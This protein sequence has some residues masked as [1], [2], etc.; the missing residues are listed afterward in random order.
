MKKKFII[1]KIL[2]KLQKMLV[3]IFFMYLLFIPKINGVININKKSNNLNFYVLKK[4]KKEYFF[5]IEKNKEIFNDNYMK[6]VLDKGNLFIQD[7]NNFNKPLSK[8]EIM[9]DNIRKHLNNNNYLD[10]YKLS[11]FFSE[12]K[13]ESNQK[14]PFYYYLLTKKNFL[15]K[16]EFLENI[17]SIIID[18]FNNEINKK[19]QSS[20][21]KLFNKFKINGKTS[22]KIKLN[23]N[24]NLNNSEISFLLPLIERNNYIFFLQNSTHKTDNRNQNNFGLGLRKFSFE[25]DYLL[26]VNSFLDYD[27]SL[28]NTRLGL[29]F[30]FW[31]EF[32]KFNINIYYGLSRWWHHNMDN[33]NN[34]KFFNDINDDEF[35]SKPATGLDF[36]IKGYF[37]S[38][39][40]LVFKLDYSK[41]FGN[42]GF[43]INSNGKNYEKIFSDPFF[44]FSID[45]NPIPLLT[46]N[47]K[48][49]QTLGKGNFQFGISINLNLNSSF[50]NQIHTKINDV[51]SSSYDH[52]YDFVDR[53]NNMML[54]Y[55]KKYIIKIFAKKEIIGPPRG[56][57]FLEMNVTH[58]NQISNIFFYVDSIFLQR[59]GSVG[60][61][62]NDSHNKNDYMMHLP[63]YDFQN[64]NSN[65]YVLKIV[66]IDV[67]GNKD[68]FYMRIEVLPPSLNKKFSTLSIYPKRILIDSSEKAKIVFEARDSDNELLTNLQ[69]VS[70]IVERFTT[71]DKHNIHISTVKEYPKGTYSAFIT[72]SSYGSALFKVKIGDKIIKDINDTVEFIAPSVDNMVLKI[73]SKNLTAKVNESI[74]LLIIVYDK[75]GKKLK[76]SD[77]EIKNVMAVDQHG[78][79]RKDSGEIHIEDITHKKSYDGKYFFLITD[80]NGELRLKISDPH[81]IGVRTYFK[82]IANNY[83]SKKI[84][85]IFTVPTSPKTILAK[86]YGHMPDFI[87]FNGMKFKRPTLSIERLGD[88]VNHNLNEDWTKFTWFNADAFCKSQNAR[89]PTKDELIDFYN[90]HPGDDLISNYGWPIVEKS[91][92]MFWTST[93]KI[94]MYFPDP[95]HY[96]VDFITG[97]IDQGIVGN[98][99]PFICVDD[100]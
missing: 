77:V 9:Q 11:S 29:G 38:V 73:D 64:I 51:F 86:M 78:E 26:G 47:I 81:G 7:N 25:N 33:L 70:F 22:I 1:F 96:H 39:P 71:Y 43:K 37:P 84:D 94:N 62:N 75:H 55:R 36:K 21:Y 24:L 19:V 10:N 57:H 17:K 93:P 6:K 60:L 50:Y 66:A 41:Y 69:D 5:F 91:F 14:N 67:L 100:N 92:S 13:K 2:N 52:K 56:R 68:I 63:N 48:R 61:Y 87:L 74:K 58:I 12:E 34:N 99:F 82:I 3:A 97:K 65:N 20:F 88:Q 35:Y 76:F 49:L 27:F 4:I 83:V 31:K 45:Y 79:V 53:N 23:E 44:S 8:T 30:E 32:I 15:N 18:S 90:A 54:K 28:E 40:E 85:L 72:S 89:L 59:G 46:F 98:I 16:E 42:V 80:E 95:L